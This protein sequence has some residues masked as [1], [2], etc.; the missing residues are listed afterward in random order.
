MK[1]NYSK[2]FSW[3]FLQAKMKWVV[4]PFLALFLLVLPQVSR[5]QIYLH[6]FGE[7]T[8]SSHPYTVSPTATPTPGILNANLSNSSWTNSFGV[9]TSFGGSTGLPNQ[10]LVLNN[11]SG[12]PTITLNVDIAA[13]YLSNITSFNFWRQR[14]GTG[15]TNWSM[16]I[17][18][19]FVGSGTVPT[20]GSFI[21]NTAVASPVNNLSG[22][23]TV[24]I[25]LTG[26]SGTGNFRLDDFT[27]NGSVVLGATLSSNT[28]TAF[29]NVCTGTTPGSNT[30]TVTGTNLTAANVTVGPLAGFTFSTD[31]IT[32]TASTSFSIPGNQ[33]KLVYIR[34]SPVAVLNYSGNSPISGGGSLSSITVAISG[35]GV[36]T[37]PAVTNGTVSGVTTSDATISATISSIGCTAISGYGIEYS[38]TPGFANGSGINVPSSNLSGGN[39]SVILSALAPPGQTFYVHVYATN[40]GGTTY[41]AEI[42]FTLLNTVPTLSVPPAGAGSLSPFGNICINTSAIHPFSLS[43]SQ[44]NNTAIT[45]G[46][47]AGYTFATSIAGVYSNT[48]TLTTGGSGYSYVAGV[49]SGCTIYVKFIPLAIQSYNG[50]IPI[51]GGGATA[52][53]VAAT[54]DGINTAPSVTT[55]AALYITTSTA[56]LPATLT[57]PGCGS[58]L[59]YGFEFSTAPFAQ[60]TGTPVAASNLSGGTFS[61][62]LSLLTPNTTYYYMAYATNSGGTSYGV[63]LSFTTFP[64]PTKLV[65]LSVNPASPTALTPFSI[66]VQAQDNAGNPVDV[67]VE[68]DIRLDQVA[69]AGFFDFPTPPASGT[70]FDGTNTAVIT[71]STYSVAENNVAIRAVPITGMVGLGNSNDLYFDVILYTGPNTF[72]WSGTG[73]SAWLTPGNWLSGTSPGTTTVAGLNQH[74]ASFTSQA[75]LSTLA[76][77]GCGINMN[78]AGGVLNVGAIYFANT[79]SFAHPANTVPIGNSSTSASGTLNLYGTTVNTVG[80]IPLNNYASLLIANYMSDANTKTLEIRN[81]QGTGDKFMTLN[82]ANAGSIVAGVGRTINLHTYMTG[83]QNITFTGGG[84]F[85]LMPGGVSSFNTFSGAIQVANGTLSLGNN[86]AFSGASP[87][88]ITLGSGTNAGILRLNG[89]SVTI[90]GLATSGTAGIS[91]IVDNGNASATLTINHSALAYTYAG[92]LNNGSTGTLSLVKAGSQ[93]LTLTGFSQYSGLTT[94]TGGTLRLFLAGGGTIPSGNSVTVSNGNLRI[95]SDQ[96]LNNLSL[97]G[98]TLTV[99]AGVTLTITGTYSSGTAAIVNN[100]TIKLNGSALQTFPGVNVTVSTMNNLTIQN[101]AGVNLNKSLNVAGVLTLTSGTFTVG[102]NTLTINNPI[103]GTPTNLS[104]NNISSII[105]AGTVAGVNLPNSVSQLNNFTVSNT[106]GTVLQGNLNIAGTMLV[107][108][109]LVDADASITLNGAGNLTMT[110]GNLRLAKNGVVLPEFTG[111]YNLT[112]GTVS[113]NGVGVTASDAQTIRPVN[114]FNLTSLSTGDRIL[115]STGVIGVSNVFTPSNNNYTITGSTVDFNKTGAQ[116]IPEFTFYNLRLS[117][118]NVTKTLAGNIKV[119]AVLTLA[120]N[121]KLSLTT[122][123]ATLLSDAT[124]TAYVEAVLA[125]NS[126][127]YGAPGTGRF[128]VERYIPTGVSHGKSWQL[129]ATPTS[130]QT[131]NEA[132]QEGNAPLVNGTPF[133]GTTLTSEKTGAVARGYDFYTPSGGPSI[134]TYNPATNLWVG[135]DDGVTNTAALPVANKK[136]YMIFVRG[137]RSVQTSATPATVTTLRTRGKLYSP[138]TDAPAS[139]TVLAGKFETVGNPYASAIDFVSLLGTSTGIDTKYYVWDPL[140]PGSLNFGGYQTISSATGYKPVPGGT[141]NYDAT[142]SYTKVQ[143][144]QAFFVYSTPGGTVNFSETNKSSANNMV[145]RTSPTEA[146]RKYL[147]V[148]LVTESGALADGNVVVFSPTFSNRIDANDAVKIENFGENFGIRSQGKILAVEARRQV[149]QTDTIFYD[150]NS[151]KVQGY[152]LKFTPEN[153]SGSHLAAWFVDSYLGTRISL[154]LGAPSTISFSVTADPGSKAAG[155]FYLVFKST[156]PAPVQHIEI[157]GIRN[158]QGDADISWNVINESGMV[159]YELEKSTD[160]KNFTPV[161]QTAS[162]GNGFANPAYLFTDK[163]AGSSDIYYRVKVVDTEGQEYFSRQVLVE[164]SGQVPGI[165]VYP[166]PVVNKTIQIHFSNQAKGRYNYTLSNNLGQVVYKGS[167]VIENLEAVKLL[168]IN[169]PLVPGNY[170]LTLRHVNASQSQ[171]NIPVNF[172]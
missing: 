76:N 16:T 70:I 22:N 51:S 65:I 18:G 8:I 52:I 151:L 147:R 19:I 90:G 86:G 33:S 156:R 91:N 24:V 83:N 4:F 142:V 73:N 136:G 92:A 11:T 118:G 102:A 55:D 161:Y 158:S 84:N 27:L 150:A 31:N 160:S 14:S 148:N 137:D 103:A 97:N 42:S 49:L 121:T 74:L 1:N 26:A 12:S 106:T 72:I 112:G 124:G 171:V 96:T 120:I 48:I 155:R 36:N 93:I 87:N 139:S 119:K 116:N 144:G 122:F 100:G 71:G 135:I 111:V 107:S 61:Y 23:I 134:K 125:N 80:G 94:V 130:G 17:N 68:T 45:I 166:N 104:A 15:A 37:A 64:V 157:T 164:G 81:T 152:Q 34:F 105:I 39:F 143:S 145:F 75:N 20:T 126:F 57:D 129:L 154:N 32:Y 59:G 47:L 35:Q 128:V 127:I 79:Y 21:G 99:D 2:G 153:F 109:G 168:V 69:G 38:T 167:L 141:A 63:Q 172:R 108:A 110:G 169:Q 114:Y 149:Y 50:N 140:L 46:P 29:G 53:T 95:S 41:G 162:L 60:G 82:I 7:T 98:G 13:G 117:G 123:D 146:A 30:F 113:F 132:W 44:L 6:N 10:S 28:P 131:M 88:V 56:T 89:N 101:V 67:N 85:S 25:S 66:T 159:S 40:A 5:S 115:S 78:G 77:G 43:G 133:F 163:E 62:D 138:G 3:N 58:L 165:R 54:G 9:F 170:Q